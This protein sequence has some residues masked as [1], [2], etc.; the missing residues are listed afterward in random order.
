MMLPKAIFF[1]LDDTIVSYSAS[2]EPTWRSVCKEYAVHD[3]RL[4]PEGLFFQI[5]TTADWYWKDEK[6]HKKG[7]LD[8]HGARRSI[9]ERAFHALGLDDAILAHRIA[10]AFS[11]QR[12]QAV[13]LFN[14]AVETLEYLKQ[15]NV[16]MALITNGAED[17][18]GR[19][20]ER[21]GLRGFFN[22]ILIE[23]RV[24]FGKPEEA[25]YVCALEALG[26]KPGQAWFVGDNLEWDVAAPQRLGIY[27]I[28][29]DYNR[30]GLPADAAIIPDRIIHS[31]TELVE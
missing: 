18:Q 1:D 22:P 21:F 13:T 28:W 19:K 27:G 26:L 29:N 9:L 8:L 16:A 3:A 6:R 24:G 25:V 15:Q 31:I 11:D 5:R 12:E 14:G 10:D 23:G 17:K 20:I 7:R 2:T 30:D 4:T